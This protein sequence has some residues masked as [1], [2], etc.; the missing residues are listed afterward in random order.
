MTHSEAEKRME[1]LAAERAA[2]GQN[3]KYNHFQWV[4][5][6]PARPTSLGAIRKRHADDHLAFDEER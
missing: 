5:D 1:Q 2:A 4:P 6:D 3:A